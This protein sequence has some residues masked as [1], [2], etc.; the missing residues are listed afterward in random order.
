MGRIM[1]TGKIMVTVDRFL[2]P[3]IGFYFRNLI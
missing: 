2:P 3:T 1:A